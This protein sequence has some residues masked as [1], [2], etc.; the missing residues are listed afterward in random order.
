MRLKYLFIIL[1]TLLGISCNTQ[2]AK[3]T[4]SIATMKI[5]SN[6]AIQLR[7]VP[8]HA[9][10]AEYDRYL[11]LVVDEK[12]VTEIQISTDTGGYSQANVFATDTGFAVQD[13]VGRY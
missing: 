11:S 9:Y 2:F 3:S 5:G 10:L 7:R 13:R 4:G 6:Y 1:A 12:T 8:A